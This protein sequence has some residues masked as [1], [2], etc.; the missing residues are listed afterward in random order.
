MPR[1][2]YCV[3]NFYYPVSQ[4][5]TD[6]SSESEMKDITTSTINSSEAL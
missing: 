2:Q 1:K 3:S 5:H 6:D 4:M